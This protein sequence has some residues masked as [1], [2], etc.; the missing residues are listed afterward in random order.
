MTL[1]RNRRRCPI[2]ACLAIALMM[3]VPLSAFAATQ[4]LFLQAGWNLVS[5]SVEPDDATVRSVLAPLIVT[6]NFEALWAYGAADGEWASFPPTAAGRMSVETVASGRGYWLKVARSAT[7]DVEGSFEVATGPGEISSGWN[8]VGF[9]LEEPTPYER[10]VTNASIRQIWTFDAT[11]GDFVGVVINPQGLVLREDFIDLEAGR[12]YWLFSNQEVSLAPVLGTGLPPDLDL[13]PL[14]S[15]DAVTSGAGGE[16]APKPFNRS[17]GDIDIAGDGFYDR[18]GSQRAIDFGE[19][20]TIQP[21]SIFNDRSGVLSWTI[22]VLDPE[23]T[24]WLRLREL[25]STT[26]MQTL[27][28]EKSGTVASETDIVDV[29]VDRIG[30]P[31]GD[32]TGALR[33]TTNAED[34]PPPSEAVRDIA[35]RM[36]VA[37]LDGDYRLT[38]EIES[39]NDRPA[40]LPDPQL[41]ISLYRDSD[42]LKVVVNEAQTLLISQ[43]LRMRGD[44][45]E[46]G[47]SRFEVSGS[48]EMPA[49]D[50]GNPYGVAV[51]RDLTLRG[52]RRDPLDPADD[53]L[54]PLDLKGEYFETIRNVTDQPIYLAGRFTAERLGPLASARDLAEADSG[55]AGNIPDGGVLERTIQIDRNILITELDVAVE[56]QHARPADLVVSLVAPDTTEAVLRD[57]SAAAVGRVL[58][59]EIAMPVDSLEIFNGKLAPG[60]YTLRI[61]DVAAGQTGTLIN[62]DLSIRGTEVHDLA[63]SVSGVPEGADLVLTG[64]GV[65]KRTTTG[66]GGSFSFENLVDCVYRITILESGFQTVSQDVVLNGADVADISI[67]P[68][69]GNPFVSTP[70]DLPSAPNAAFVVLTTA[71][72]A[73]SLEPTR[74]RQYVAEATT[75]DVDRPPLGTFPEG[76][77]TNDFLEAVDP[78]TRSNVVGINGRVDGPAGPSSRRLTVTIGQPVIGS[79][80]QGSLRLSVGANP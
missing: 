37:E 28:I 17:A 42:G 46:T 3:A 29:I 14:V 50:P 59:D 55:L 63:G 72:G 73:G 4:R 80:V 79:S 65:A 43:R 1:Q 9:A 69:A 21:I 57:R 75:F 41:T 61:E 39:I 76:P 48:Y 33:I 60:I 31:P 32:L 58:Y 20:Q 78:L 45:Y 56:L 47:T 25:D 27:L 52:E 26:R 70:V 36:S 12:G 40:D 74:A 67:E 66:A 8:L 2:A 18:T 6:D 51:R 13:P 62:W 53:I 68:V 54:G 44:F 7:I 38:A 22:E 10:I 11:Q 77:D 64:C 16:L 15:A 23:S 19:R 71:G 35:V 34:L 30:L 49:D 24:P 5:F